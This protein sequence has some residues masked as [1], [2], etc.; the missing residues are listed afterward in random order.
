MG[1]D[2]FP[3]VNLGSEPLKR[4]R[5]YQ[6]KGYDQ[7]VFFS[8]RRMSKSCKADLVKKRKGYYVVVDAADTDLTKEERS[9]WRIGQLNLEETKKLVDNGYLELMQKVFD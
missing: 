7:R 5:V 2:M 3:K 6:T 9:S 1:D 4:G 8:S